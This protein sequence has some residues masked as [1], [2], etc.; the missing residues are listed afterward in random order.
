MTIE[1]VEI[2]PVLL[3]V[4]LI[5]LVIA[6]IVLVVQ[7]IN[8]LKKVDIILDDVNKKMVKV[9]GV[10]NIIDNVTDYA[11]GMSDKIIGGI[12]NIINLIFR[13]KKGNDEYE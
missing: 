4:S 8:T 9:D 13:R 11:A 10:F 2:L 6:L 5:A 1:L 7:V 3:Y 12:T